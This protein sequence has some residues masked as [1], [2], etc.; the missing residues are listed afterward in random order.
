[1]A[2]SDDAHVH[3]ADAFE[4]LFRDGLQPG[5]AAPKWEGMVFPLGLRMLPVE[6]VVLYA[7]VAR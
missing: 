7:R 3:R 1:M 5:T 4:N 2:I 6:C